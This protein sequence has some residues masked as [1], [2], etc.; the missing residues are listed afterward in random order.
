MKNALMALCL[1]V[2]LSGCVITDKMADNF[3]MGPY[4]V[5]TSHQQ[6][7]ELELYAEFADRANTKC[8]SPTWV[9]LDRAG[10]EAK[11]YTVSQEDLKCATDVLSDIIHT[12]HQPTREPANVFVPTPI[13]HSIGQ[14][15]AVSAR[16]YLAQDR[17][18]VVNMQKHMKSMYEEKNQENRQEILNASHA[19]RLA[20]QLA[21]QTLSEYVMHYA[22]SNDSENY[23]KFSAA[24]AKALEPGYLEKQAE[25]CLVK[26]DI[27][28]KIKHEE[29]TSDYSSVMAEEVAKIKARTY[30]VYSFEGT[31]YQLNVRTHWTEEEVKSGEAPATLK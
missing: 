2:G 12:Y 5:V 31:D 3:T 28:K 29:A 7:Q 15:G 27:Y 13:L 10:R 16:V 14:Y 22:R 11:V 26:S 19:C 18:S 4:P 9:K 21:V 6:K 17:M 1:V 23:K 25:E 8:N 20:G 24:Y 30:P